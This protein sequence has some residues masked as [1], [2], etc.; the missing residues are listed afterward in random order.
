MLHIVPAFCCDRFFLLTIKKSLISIYLLVII[1][2]CSW[3]TII[4]CWLRDLLSSMV[5]TS[6]YNLRTFVMTDKI[7]KIY[8]IK[9]VS[10]LASLLTWLFHLGSRPRLRHQHQELNF[11]LLLNVKGRR[12]LFRC[13]HITSI[14][15]EQDHVG[16][17]MLQL[18]HLS[19]SLL[20][21]SFIVVDVTPAG[22]KMLY[23]VP[24]SLSNQYS[25]ALLFL[26]SWRENVYGQNKIMS[27]LVSQ[28]KII[29]FLEEDTYLFADIFH[30]SQNFFCSQFAT[31]WSQCTLVVII[32]VLCNPLWRPIK[33]FKQLISYLAADGDPSYNRALLT[34]NIEFVWC[35][36]WI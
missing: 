12:T 29:Q 28:L 32:I 24:T 26:L 18:P 22:I 13:P 10:D 19:P 6:T 11:I 30:F 9:I 23:H 16:M 17:D 27:L 4:F 25:T 15:Q 35:K 14:Y 34:L 33:N 7:K 36:E 8:C 2:Y 5:Y 20:F 31:A 3:L 1:I 21:A